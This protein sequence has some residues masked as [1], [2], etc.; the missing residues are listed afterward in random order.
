MLADLEIGRHTPQRKLWPKIARLL[1]FAPEEVRQSGV[2]VGYC[3]IL[4]SG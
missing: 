2:W 3:D 4:R 1:G